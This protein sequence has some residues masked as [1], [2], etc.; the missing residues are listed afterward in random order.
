MSILNRRS[1]DISKSLGKLQAMEI[2]IVL[3]GTQRIT[4]LEALRVEFL[5][6][7]S[8]N[9]HIKSAMLLLLLLLALLFLYANVM[10]LIP[11]KKKIS[12]FV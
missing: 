4:N 10:Y 1:R 2:S 3:L 12:F 8:R 9:A 7:L 11:P 6:L 5:A